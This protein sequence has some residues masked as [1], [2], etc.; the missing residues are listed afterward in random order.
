MKQGDALLPLLLNITL[1]YAM[2]KVQE[3]EEGLEF[4]ET[5]QLLVYAHNVSM[6]GKNTN[7]IKRNNS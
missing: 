3:N 7:T 6:L 5:Q 1:E 4:S 2:W